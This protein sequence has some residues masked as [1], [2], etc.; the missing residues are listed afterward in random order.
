MED[1]LR[2]IRE[3]E[4]E[5]DRKGR[6]LQDHEKTKRKLEAELDD[7]KQHYKK[8]EKRLAGGLAPLGL[9]EMK[10]AITGSI[11]GAACWEEVERLPQELVRVKEEQNALRRRMQTHQAEF[12]QKIEKLTA[13]RET[14]L[15]ALV[16][17]KT[18]REQIERELGEMR[19]LIEQGRCPTCRQ[20]V[21]AETFGEVL[22][23]REERLRRL[24]A[25]I[26]RQEQVLQ[27][28]DERL[29]AL[30]SEG[31]ESTKQ[32][33]AEFQSLEAKRSG[34]EAMKDLVERL[35]RIKEQGQEKRDLLKATVE[36]A[37]ALRDELGRLQAKLADKKR[38]L[39][40]ADRL[41]AQINQ[42]Q[43]ILKKL[44]EQRQPVKRKA[45]ALREK[46]G[47][48]EQKI[49]ERAKLRE[50]RE[51]VARELR[52]IEALQGELEQLTELYG[53]VKRELRTRNIRAL[54]AYF[55]RFFALM[56]SG[57][58]Y[59]GVRVSDEYEINVELKD[60]SAIRPE[61]LSGGERALINIALRSAIHQVLS[62]A[63]SRM[64][65]ILDE[66][67]IYLDRDRIQRLQFLLEE[68]GR[69]V[70]QVIVVSHELGLVEGADH[71]YRTE[72]QAN[73]TSR[74]QRVR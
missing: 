10:G 5:L 2:E 68:L 24:C 37:E 30:K 39:G 1:T 32:L 51:R 60:G 63:T 46:R 20:P 74:V 14:H 12:T 50:E 18:Q 36:S 35:L 34:L 67:T 49:E 57:A 23:E 27:K 65:L 44:A 55:N 6:R 43:G 8:L 53:S 47:R 26:E 58:S 15:T 64:P 21:S 22:T 16:E 62:Q 17:Q 33:D 38:E 3:G 9:A 72:K 61:L 52:R 11:K 59:R 31:Q 29:R 70:G 56:D 4:R 71:E 41:Q 7:L 48:I 13:E 69:R 25:Q 73:N 28:L 54:E 19:A 42:I 45:D 40:D 66:P